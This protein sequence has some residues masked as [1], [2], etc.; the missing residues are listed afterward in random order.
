MDDSKIKIS[1]EYRDLEPVHARFMTLL[2]KDEE[3]AKDYWKRHKREIKRVDGG[4]SGD[5]APDYPW[6]K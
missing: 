6:M 4:M 2:D 3:K 1:S 5:L